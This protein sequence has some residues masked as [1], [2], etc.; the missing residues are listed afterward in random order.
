MP[1]YN[2]TGKKLT[3]YGKSYSSGPSFRGA[4]GPKSPGGGTKK[5]GGLMK[6]RNS[7]Y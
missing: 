5:G 6:K 3:K 2:T 1:M 7:S 4:V